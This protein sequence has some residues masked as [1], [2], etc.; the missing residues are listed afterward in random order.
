VAV[1]FFPHPTFANAEGL[2]AIGG[3]LEPDTL[4]LA[5]HFGI[6][7]WYSEGQQ[8]LWWS[9]HP[10][11]ILH[12]ADIKISKSMRSL[13][14]KDPYRVTADHAFNEVI[15]LCKHHKRNHQSGTWITDE[16]EWAYKKL[17]LAGV[18]H[19]IEVWEG[20]HLVAGLYGLSLGKVFFGESMFTLVSNG[21][22]YGF[23]RLAKTLRQLNYRLID[24]QQDTAHLR[25]LGASLISRDTFLQ[26]LAENRKLP[27]DRGSW[28]TWDWIT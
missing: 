28:Y 3:D 11:L 10:R 14:N 19:S 12:P 2:L 1:P 26:A 16:M 5:Y 6:F 24:C 22:K 8:I 21:S 13:L 7:P 23:I 4:V 9:P 27:E 18:A 17:H 25:S 20:D 15:H